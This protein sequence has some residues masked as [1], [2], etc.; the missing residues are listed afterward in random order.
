MITTYIPTKDARDRVGEFRLERGCSTD[1]LFML[2]YYSK[3]IL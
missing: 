1:S 2:I 3:N